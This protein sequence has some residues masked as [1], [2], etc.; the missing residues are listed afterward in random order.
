MGQQLRQ[1]LHR[2]GISSQTARQFW[3]YSQAFSLKRLSL[4]CSQH[5]PEVYPVG[6]NVTIQP[7]STTTNTAAL[8][9]KKDPFTNGPP[10]KK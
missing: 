3:N 4:L 6:M 9:C 10:P 5:T 1:L 7:P 2:P 8:E